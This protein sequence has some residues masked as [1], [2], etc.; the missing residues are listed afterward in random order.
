MAG[1]SADE[2]L[3]AAKVPGRTAPSM[4]STGA[5]RQRIR[6]RIARTIQGRRDSRQ[7]AGGREPSEITLHKGVRILQNPAAQHKRNS[8][9]ASGS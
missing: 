1:K 8:P 3:G 2:S 4:A 9:Q 7:R 5:R 6:K